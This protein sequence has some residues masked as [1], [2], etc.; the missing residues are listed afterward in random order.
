[1]SADYRENQL[2]SDRFK[3]RVMR[4]PMKWLLLLAFCET[5]IYRYMMLAVSMIPYMGYVTKYVRPL[6]YI[7]LILKCYQTRRFQFTT[8]A[9]GVLLFVLFAIIG[10][11]LIYPQNA[12]YILD[13]NN[14]WNTIFPCFRF[15][16]VGLIVVIDD[17]S[18]KLLGKV[19]CIAIL[20]E[21]LF[22]VGYIIPNGLLNG[23]EMSRAY[24]ILPNVMFVY[25]YAVNYKKFIGWIFSGLGVFYILLMGTRGPMV[26]FLVYILIRFLISEKKENLWERIV[27]ITALLL[28]CVFFASDLFTDCVSYVALKL[29]QMGLTTRTFDLFLKQEFLSHTSGRDEIY[30][31]AIERLKD[32]PY[33]GYGVYGDWQ[34]FG[35]NCH[36]MY[37]ELLLHFGV[38]LGP[39][40]LLWGLNLVRKAYFTSK[41]FE[42]KNMI[43]IFACIVFVRGFF[44]G[45]YLMYGVFFLIGFCLSEYRRGRSHNQY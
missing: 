6:L 20:L 28:L 33:L 13:S 16:L 26:I 21:G 5:N 30:G 42:A 37:L 25:A 27:K 41:S 1:M 22:L 24:A 35:W 43:L 8:K 9:L 15:F 29:N 11:C 32:H 39:L 44:G 18:M 7:V 45:S 2:Y 31:I 10:T 19:S 34:F 40:L 12:E 36:N 23:D 4:D 38:I 17:D 14:F 3:I